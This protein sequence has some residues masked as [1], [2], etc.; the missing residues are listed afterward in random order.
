MVMQNGIDIGQEVLQI[1]T[2]PNVALSCDSVTVLPGS[3]PIELKMCEDRPR[4]FAS[5]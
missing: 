2:K 3:F 1:L 5:T 4:N